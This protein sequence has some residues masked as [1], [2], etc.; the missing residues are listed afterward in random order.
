MKYSLMEEK[1]EHNLFCEDNAKDSLSNRKKKIGVMDP[2]RGCAIDTR[3]SYFLFVK[4]ILLFYSVTFE[5][6]RWK[7]F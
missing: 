7:H 1:K 2:K 3:D 5:I 6:N 4:G